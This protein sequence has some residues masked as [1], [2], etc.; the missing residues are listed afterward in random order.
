[1]LFGGWANF[2][3]FAQHFRCAPRTH[4]EVGNQNKGF[5]KLESDEEKAKYAPLMQTIAIPPGH[6]LIFYERIVHEVLPTLHVRDD[7]MVRMMLGFRITDDTEPL[8]GRKA[9]LRWIEKQAV[10]RIKSAQWPHMFPSCYSSYPKNFQTLT[11]W[12]EATFVPECLHEH[13]VRGK[14]K[15]NGSR[16]PRVKAHMLSLAEYGLPLHEAYDEDEKWL[17]VPQR[18]W[19]LRTFDNINDRALIKGVTKKEWRLYREKKRAAPPGANIA[20]PRPQRVV[21]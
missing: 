11:D 1:M 21:E 7:P 10:P 20:R 8:F 4:L 6:V 14:G 13:V 16:W 15:A 5:A 19:R 17:L 18:S 12:S 9:T 2:D 3:D